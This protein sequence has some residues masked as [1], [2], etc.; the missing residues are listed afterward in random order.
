MF[1][2]VPGAAEL[3]HPVNL[4]L[5]EA[6][7]EPAP[8]CPPLSGPAET[9]VAVVGAGFLGAAT[10]LALAER[11]IAVTLLEASPGP[12]GGA[13]GRSGGQVIPGLRHDPALLQQ[14]YGR[15]FGTRLD[16]VAAGGG[17]ATFELIARHRIACDAAPQGW[18]QVMDT[19]AELPEMQERIRLWQAR[20]I[21]IHQLSRQ[22]VAAALGSDNYLGGWINPEGGS[23]QPLS[24]VRGLVRAAQQA[25]A[26][27]HAD[28][29]VQSMQRVGA[30]WDLQT[31]RGRL[32]ARRVMLATNTQDGGL[33]PGLARSA[34]PVWSFQVATPPLSP[35]QAHILPEGLAVS[36]TRRVLRYFRRDGTGR[37]VVGGKGTLSRPRQLGQFATVR[38]IL[39]RLYPE[40][41]AAPLDF[42][43]GGRVAVTPGRWPR[44][45]R[46]GPDAWS[47]VV[48]NGKGVALT[49]ALAPHLAEMLASGEEAASPL[50][51]TALAPIPGFGLRRLYVGAGSAW[52][53]LQDAL[54]RR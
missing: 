19:E 37:L 49:T 1:S 26:R 4:S 43:W 42:A 8:H 12:G 51:A 46:L 9:E 29:P 6:T 24:Y 20:G 21:P 28:S 45:V 52:L 35:A 2:I 34:L 7:A 47:V 40:L 23:L 5:W 14:E 11:G 32:R 13:S 3:L 53:R 48:C 50:P 38:R 25:G 10:A 15:E 54:E 30:Q 41:A 31:P 27:V 36:D 44:M 18:M 22:E 33:W 39:A 17:R 16:A